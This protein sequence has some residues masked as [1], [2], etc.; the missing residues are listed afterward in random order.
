MNQPHPTWEGEEQK[1][2]VVGLNWVII[3]T[4]LSIYGFL[5]IV[6]FFFSRSKFY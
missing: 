3:I 4:A 5:D 2:S 6:D 1:S